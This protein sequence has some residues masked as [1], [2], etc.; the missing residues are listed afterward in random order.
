MKKTII[1]LPYLLLLWTCNKNETISITEFK[2]YN[3]KEQ[4]NAINSLSSTSRF[5][6]IRELLVANIYQ[7]QNNSIFKFKIDGTVDSIIQYHP[8]KKN[9]I[10]KLYWL[11]KD[12]TFIIW[13]I[14]KNIFFPNF[15]KRKNIY[16]AHIN[17]FRNQKL[18]TRELS[19]NFYNNDPD[20]DI[21]TL[22]L[23]NDTNSNILKRVSNIFL[24]N[25]IK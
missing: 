16:A 25:K 10:Q 21:F 22:Y 4:A 9:K 7:T 6:F 24:S 23:L 3:V 5:K 14:D 18:I 19:I 13:K 8:L 20:R 12:D 15:I 11:I 1:I 17:I 2:K